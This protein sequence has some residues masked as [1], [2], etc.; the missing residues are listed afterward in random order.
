MKAAG[1][2]AAVTLEAVEAAIRNLGLTPRGAF[3]C[4]AEDAVPPQP[5]G[6]ESRTLILIGNVGGS[7]WPS[8]RSAPEAHDGRR[9]PLNRWSERMIGGLAAAF[10][11]LAL[12]PFGGPPYQPFLR[13]ARRAEP[14]APS[15]L[16]MLIHPDYG[17]WHAYRG[18]IALAAALP[19]PP[20]DLRSSPCE[21]CAGR[22]CLSACPVGAFTVSGY[23]A[24][25]CA[26]HIAAP[27]GVDCMDLGC[28]ARRACPV[29]REYHY[30]GPQA[31]LHMEAFLAARRQ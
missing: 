4:T 23:D 27:A 15:P 9:D 7:F 25:S 24:A 16:G 20:R 1:K 18:A 8:Y 13:W 12:F 17:L 11:A 26:G 29:G 30:P 31:R 22:P 28:R 6:R 14:V 21:S 5:G 2:G 19:L 3:A 10:D